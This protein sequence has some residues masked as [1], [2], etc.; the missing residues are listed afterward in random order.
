MSKTDSPVPAS[1][2]IGRLTAATVGRGSRL[3]RKNR[4]KARKMNGASGDG[5]NN[6]ARMLRNVLVDVQ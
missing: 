1:T 6:G 5:E 4:A 3:G 2:S